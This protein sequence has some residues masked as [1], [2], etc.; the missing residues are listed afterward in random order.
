MANLKSLVQEA[1]MNTLLAKIE[2][3]NAFNSYTEMEEIMEFYE[4]MHTE[5]R[6]NPT[7]ALER[8]INMGKFIHQYLRIQ[9]WAQDLSVT[10]N[11]M[12]ESH[13][14]KVILETKLKEVKEEQDAPILPVELKHD[15]YDYD[16]L[17]CGDKESH[18]CSI[19]LKQLTLQDNG[20]QCL[21]CDE[22]LVTIPATYPKDAQE[23]RPYGRLAQEALILR[24]QANNKRVEAS[25]ADYQGNQDM[26]EKCLQESYRLDDIAT[27]I[28]NE[29]LLWTFK[30]WWVK[31]WDYWRTHTSTLPAPSWATTQCGTCITRNGFHNGKCRSHFR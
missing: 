21:T 27:R 31:S 15:E 18:K 29:K 10:F 12:H 2:R 14:E 11:K 6:S 22:D 13:L 16:Y 7:L 3:D 28:F 1:T 20:E 30:P 9:K 23:A 19:C 25:D 17:G 8:N 26:R 4:K 5:F 24:I